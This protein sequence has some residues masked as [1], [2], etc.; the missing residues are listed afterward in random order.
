VRNEIL[1]YAVEKADLDDNPYTRDNVIVYSDRNL[2]K[3][4]SIDGYQFTSGQKKINQRNIYSVFPV[5]EVRSD[6]LNSEYR[7]DLKAWLRKYPIPKNR[8]IYSKHS[9]DK[10]VHLKL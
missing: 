10:K 2:G 6:V 4:Y 7:S 8:N 5:R 9:R 1:K 3:I